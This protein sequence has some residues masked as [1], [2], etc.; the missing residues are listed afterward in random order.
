MQFFRDMKSRILIAGELLS[1]LWSRKLWVLIPFVSVIL[2]LGLIT[3]IGTTS[4]V[5]PFI[6][7]LF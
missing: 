1:F 4:G 7:T 3:I 5:G 6:Y 2:L